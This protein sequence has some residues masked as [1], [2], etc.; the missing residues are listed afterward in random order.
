MA[1]RE[2]HVVDEDVVENSSSG[3]VAGLLRR[4]FRWMLLA[5][6]LTVPGDNPV[7]T[8]SWQ[9][10]CDKS[11]L[12]SRAN[13]R[14]D[15]K[16]FTSTPKENI[17]SVVWP[18]G[19]THPFEN[20]RPTFDDGPHPNDLQLIETLEELPFDPAPIFYYNGVN[21]F[22]AETLSELELDSDNPD[23]YQIAAGGWM[24]YL[25]H[26][27]QEQ[28]EEDLTKVLRGMMD[29]EKMGIA[30]S[31]LDSGMII[32]FHG[33]LHAQA[34]SGHHMSDLD[35]EAFADELEFFELM[36]I[37]ATGDE[38]YVV[39]NVRPPFGAGMSG[40]SDNDFVDVCEDRGIDLR[41]WSFSSN[42]WTVGEKD[43]EAMFAKTLRV[44]KEGGS[45]DILY[46]SAHQDGSTRGGFGE[47]VDSFSG[48]VL[49]L[50]DEDREA[51]VAGYKSLL[52]GVLERK[53]IPVGLLQNSDYQVGSMQQVAADSAYNKRLNTQYL[54]ALQVAAKME[55]DGYMGKGTIEAVR[56][57]AAEHLK[58][59]SDFELGA[60]LK[61]A[62]SFLDS[63]LQEQLETESGMD[64]GAYP[65][66]EEMM[67][68]GVTFGNRGLQSRQIAWDIECRGGVDEMF[69]KTYHPFG[70]HI[71]SSLID[72][73]VQ[74]DGF[75]VRQ[76]L[77]LNTR[78][79]IMAIV[80]LESG[81]KNGWDDLGI[82][83]GTAESIGNGLYGVIGGTNIAPL[84]WV[85][86][87]KAA[88]TIQYGVGSYGVGQ[89]NMAITWQM[90]EVI[91]GRDLSRDEVE[92]I[93]DTP[94]GS[95][96]STYLYL[97]QYEVRMWSEKW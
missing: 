73:Y 28:E 61:D 72:F 31:V 13:T 34:E 95:A 15:L 4:S 25:R 17:K 78:A 90:F 3:R 62:N 59:T 60:D 88:D 58:G 21:F 35:K 76:G 87:D 8:V 56:A 46:H 36:V 19:V 37:V 26:Q 75:M 6:V 20:L 10:N 80:L 83:K 9:N 92:S 54:G 38:D 74:M 14:F 86:M 23:D 29:E 55:A 27:A 70:L 49:S 69:L 12:V 1:L 68:G 47:L 64:F 89:P 41:T 11:V 84:R 63:D 50:L 66:L 7:N 33:M 85:G 96:F 43:G 94:E 2:R 44:I 91:L 52:E 97:R 93:L 16:G 81:V 22:N 79:R 77:D 45:P 65:G 82:G 67:E 51:E 39:Q 32:G 57:L 42:D 40:F 5:S 18:S 48:H 30:K 71:E 24:Q 53:S